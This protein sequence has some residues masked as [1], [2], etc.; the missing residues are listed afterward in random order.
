MEEMRAV[1]EF[2]QGR[3]LTIEQVQKARASSYQTPGVLHPC[4]VCVCLERISLCI[5]V[6]AKPCG[7][8]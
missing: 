4:S 3:G 5:S 8:L 7:C 6:A 2:L 1:V